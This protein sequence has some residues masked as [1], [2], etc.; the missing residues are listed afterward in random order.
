MAGTREPAQHPSARL[1]LDCREILSPV[2]LPNQNVTHP[3]Y[4]EAARRP[5]DIEPR[6]ERV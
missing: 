4:T 6:R 5:G 3:D 1:L 2:P